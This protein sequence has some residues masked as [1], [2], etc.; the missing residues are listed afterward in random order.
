[1][2]SFWTLFKQLFKQKAKSA[3]LLIAIQV[4]AALVLTLLGLISSHSEM[5][6]AQVAGV[7]IQNV[8]M[9]YILSFVLIFLGLGIPVTMVYFVMTSWKNEKI[10][11]SQTWRLVPIS[12][13]KLYIVNTL[14]SFAVFIYLN[15]IQAVITAIGGLIIYFSSNDIRK[16]EVMIITQLNK[17]HFWSSTDW[18]LMIQ[19]IIAALLLGLAAYITVSFYHFITRALIDFL[20][21]KAATLTSIVVRVLMMVLVI[22]LITKFFEIVSQL[23]NSLFAGVG[24][25]DFGVIVLFLLF[26]II[27]GGINIVLIKKFVEAK[28]DR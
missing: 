22:W 8:I 7:A 10:N 19:F 9:V 12:S 25:G 20:P 5:S 18:G 28:G 4:V 16:G 24:S 15:I 6:H 1:M 23:Y 26:D 27:F 17:E 3:Y 13:E 2:T 14:T 11:R 21:N